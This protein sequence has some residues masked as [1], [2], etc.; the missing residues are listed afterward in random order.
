MN[1][2]INNTPEQGAELPPFLNIVEGYLWGI[3]GQPTGKHPASIDLKRLRVIT[4]QE[5]VLDLA[6]MADLDLNDVARCMSY[7]GY[8]CG[9]ADGKLGWFV[10]INH[11]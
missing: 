2:D 6:D 3:N 8:V 11:K 7:L 1:N 9:S 5:I 10:E 4:S